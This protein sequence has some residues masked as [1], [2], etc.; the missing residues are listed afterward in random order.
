MT[1]FSFVY[2]DLDDTLLD[3]R[4]AEKRALSDVAKHHPQLRAVP[5]AEISSAYHKI[6]AELWKAYADGDITSSNL[7]RERFSQLL[8]QLGIANI[9]PGDL[10]KQYM[11]RYS[12]H[13]VPIADAIESLHHVARHLP[14]GLITNGFADVQRA[15]LAQFPAITNV[16][17][18][19]VISEEVG[20]MKPHPDL[21]LAAK[22][23]SGS[24]G[25]ILYVGDSFHSD[26]VGGVRAGWSVAW[27]RGQHQDETADDNAKLASLAVETGADSRS[28]VFRFTDWDA[29][30]AVVAG[31]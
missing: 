23:A 20:A 4:L 8:D 25:D 3:H 26:V 18:A 30:R 12:Q 10:G 22:V 9:E 17:A 1:G 11:A 27:Y 21:F 19:T 24:D 31:A 16:L 7:R 2:F 29:M 13:W 14:V 5:V 15:K 6:N 28:R